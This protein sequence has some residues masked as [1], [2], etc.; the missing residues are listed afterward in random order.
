MVSK[1]IEPAVPR[2][3]LQM[4]TVD[5]HGRM[6]AIHRSDKVRSAKNVWSYP[7][8]LHDIGELVGDVIH[9][10]L[11]EE[12]NLEALRGSPIGQ[13]ENIISDGEGGGKYHWVMSVY[14]VRI[15]TYDDIVNKEP[16]KHDQIQFHDYREQ[17]WVSLD[18]H[19][20]FHDW[21]TAFHAAI[22]YHMGVLINVSV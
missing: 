12:F 5:A 19:K 1:W 11:M 20:T 21:A 13:Y 17:A 8:G 15:R 2:H 10:E 4:L 7:T 18:F 22:E 14:G 6:M 3:C 16:D 9:R